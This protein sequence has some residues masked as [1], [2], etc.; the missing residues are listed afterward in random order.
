MKFTL[1]NLH[2]SP[3]ITVFAVCNVKVIKNMYLY[4]DSD[5]ILF[6]RKELHCTHPSVWEAASRS[7]RSSHNVIWRTVSI[8]DCPQ[9]HRNHDLFCYPL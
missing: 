8:Y 2:H 6:D 9:E 4:F 1:T 3:E 5:C 7:W